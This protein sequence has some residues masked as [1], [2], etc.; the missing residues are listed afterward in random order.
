MA[1]IAAQAW[2]AGPASKDWSG[3][4]KSTASL[5]GV[6]R[7]WIQSARAQAWL[8]RRHLEICRV[9]APTFEEG[10]RAKHLRR[11]LASF[12]HRPK[13]DAAGNV[14]VPIIHSAKLPFIAVTA[15][16]DTILA[17]ARP[18]DIK[19]DANG[20]MWG[21]GVTDN[22]TGL[23]SLVALAKILVRPLVPEP[24]RNTLLVANVAEEG[25][26]NLHGIR[27]VARHSTF[28]ASIDRYMV[29][30]GASISH[31][32]TAA[33]GSRRFELVFEGE[34]GHSW[35]DF[36][37]A[38]PVHALARAVNLMT[39]AKLPRKPR[40]TLSVGVIHGGTSVNAIPSSA[41]AKVDVRSLDDR[42]IDRVS[43]IVE[44]AARMAV[45]AE[46]RRANDRLT[47]FQIREIGSRPAAPELPR[48]PIADCFRA[49]DDHLRITSTFDCASTDANVPLAAG[50]PTVAVGSG[51]RG[52]NTHAPGEWYD[53]QGREL[54]LR[55]LILALASLQQHG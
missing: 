36:G 19:V 38:N 11:L 26:G 32:T 34:G 1:R 40:T 50:V 2:S 52:G 16:M 39:E 4:V 55:R 30:D 7:A 47:R 6:Q 48:N 31:I 33:L 22:G 18:S 15:H 28:S 27:Y 44:E 24:R 17:P 54:G 25:E 20:T 9:P 45:L 13:I 42:E 35:N 51:G 8:N 14:V 5:D 49:V 29:L 3:R 23:T 37:R 43:G 12:G 53:P 10:D 21:P 46:N 41:R